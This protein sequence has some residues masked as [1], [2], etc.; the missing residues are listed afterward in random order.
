MTRPATARTGT[1][2]RPHP[3]GAGTATHFYYDTT[4]GHDA[5]KILPGEYYVA[6]DEMVL[7]T[8]LGSC[9]SACIWDR[10]TGIG[11]MNHFMLPETGEVDLAGAAGRYGTYAMELLI[12]ELMKKGARRDALEAKLFG[13]GN[14]M[15]NF[16]TLNVGERNAAF[17]EKFLET[18]RIRVTA[19]DLLDIYPRKVVFFTHSGRALVKKLR[20]DRSETIVKIESKYKSTLA[21]AKPATTGGDIELF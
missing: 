13:G 2:P 15:R 6:S 14:V 10:T 8:V 4:F 12:N 7:V 20:E 3:T 9:V 5:A 18:E 17:A 21:V 19:K 16:T 1:A 11:G